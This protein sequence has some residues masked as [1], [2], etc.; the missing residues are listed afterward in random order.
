MNGNENSE[1]CSFMALHV[2]SLH[3]VFSKSLDTPCILHVSLYIDITFLYDFSRIVLLTQIMY[4]FIDTLIL[5][6]KLLHFAN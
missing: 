5:Q 3:W 2:L 1:K 6:S 4:A